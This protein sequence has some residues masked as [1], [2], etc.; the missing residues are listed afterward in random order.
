MYKEKGVM[1]L[2]QEILMLLPERLQRILQQEIIEWDKLQEIRIRCERRIVLLVGGKKIIP[3]QNGQVVNRRE[4]REVLEHISKYSIYA[5]EDEIKKGYL[6]ISGG[7]R[8]GVAGKAIMEKGK[9]KT[10]RDITFLNIRVAR[11]QKGCGDKV[12]S[13]LVKGDEFF[14]TLIVSPPGAGKTTLLRDLI[15]LLAEKKNVSVVDERSEIAGCYQGIPRRDLGEHCDVLEACEKSEGI[16]MML[17]SMAPEIIAVDEIGQ[18][19]D[20]EAL[21]AAL[22]SG[23]QLLAT[24]HGGNL[25][26]IIGKPLLRQMIEEK[27]FKRI[28]LLKDA[29]EPGRIIGVYDEEGKVVVE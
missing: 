28:I 8:V 13:Y 20:Y 21:Q 23:C 22:T 12:F 27:M 25:S 9:I 14:S 18:N 19:T 29:K 11:E 5:F 2:K 15:R 16:Y 24:V 26:D 7:H 1:R 6:T 17:R 4:F 10:L 3:E